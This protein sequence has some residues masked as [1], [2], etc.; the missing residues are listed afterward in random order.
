MTHGNVPRTDSEHPMELELPATGD[1]YNRRPYEEQS[2]RRRTLD[3]MR[4]L[5]E[6]IKTRRGGKPA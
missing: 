3:D 1:P 5:S 4:K 2:A 6:A